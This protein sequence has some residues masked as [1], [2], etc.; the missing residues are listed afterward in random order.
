MFNAN[1]CIFCFGDFRWRSFVIYVSYLSNLKTLD[2]VCCRP[3][4]NEFL[5]SLLVWRPHERK[6]H[7]RITAISPGN[8]W[9]A[10]E[11]KRRTTKWSTAWHVFFT[12]PPLGPLPVHWGGKICR[13]SNSDGHSFPQI[14]YTYLHKRYV[15]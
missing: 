8:V 1:L 7:W 12:I 14:S 10:T 11:Y 13:Y 6:D 3:L 2:E 5:L 4:S 15:Y 9:W